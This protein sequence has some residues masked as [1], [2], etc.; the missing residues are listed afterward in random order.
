MK[1]IRAIRKGW[2]TFDKPKEEPK[3]YNLW[4]DDQAEKAGGLAYIP[5][6]KPQLPG[7]KLTISFCI[8]TIYLEDLE[9]FFLSTL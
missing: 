4:G 9:Y 2:I 8:V 1:L 6:P 3:V 5:A 7:L